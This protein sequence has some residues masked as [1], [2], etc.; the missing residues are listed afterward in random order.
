M[1]NSMEDNMAD[2]QIGTPA[3][4]SCFFS[5][6][7]YRASGCTGTGILLACELMLKYTYNASLT[8]LLTHIIQI[9]WIQ[10]NVWLKSMN[11]LYMKV[12]NLSTFIVKMQFSAL[13]YVRIASIKWLTLAFTVTTK[14]NAYTRWLLQISCSLECHFCT[15]SEINYL[16]HATQRL[17]LTK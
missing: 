16:S 2:T 1:Q 11:I 5:P 3:G 12:N 9:S 10:C 6:F 13:G 4:R 15:T 14:V 17:Q 7:L 8:Y